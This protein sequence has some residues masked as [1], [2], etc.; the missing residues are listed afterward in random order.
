MEFVPSRS[1]ENLGQ[2]EVGRLQSQEKCHYY[3]A[4]HDLGPSDFICWA[5]NHIVLVNLE[6]QYWCIIINFILGLQ[7]G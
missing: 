1:R 7:T 3:A 4:G 2:L 6:T 5:G